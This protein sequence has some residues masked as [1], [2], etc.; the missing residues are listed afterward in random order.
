MY[1]YS[2]D[3]QKALYYFQK[4]LLSTSEYIL[5]DPELILG[6][7]G[8]TYFYLNKLDSA[9][10]YIGKAYDLD[11]RKSSHWSIPYFYMAAIRAKKEKY[12]EALDYYRV[13]ISVSKPNTVDIVRGYNGMAVAFKKAAL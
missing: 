8:E 3:Y 12:K 11:V 9:L 1:Y 7:I 10:Y 6:F 13:S 4:P 5:N 2:G